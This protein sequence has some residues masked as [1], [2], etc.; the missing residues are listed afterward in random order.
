MTVFDKIDVFDYIGS[1]KSA[2]CRKV[3]SPKSA[4]CRKVVSPKKWNFTKKWDFLKTG[5]SLKNKGLVV[6]THTTVVVSQLWCHRVH[7]PDV[8]VSIFRMSPSRYW[9]R[10]GTGTE[11][12]LAK[13]LVLAKRTG[14]S[15][16]DWFKPR[17]RLHFSK[18]LRI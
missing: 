4:K 6:R 10:V 3:V 2:K 9:H 8:T 13:R 15:Q 17:L 12:V 11:S 1:R 14:F 18:Y 5:I 7:F 16:K